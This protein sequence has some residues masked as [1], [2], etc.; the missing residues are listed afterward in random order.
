M[1]DVIEMNKKNIKN[2]SQL[3]YMTEAFDN[4]N[5]PA[6]LDRWGPENVVQVYNPQLG[7]QGVLVIDN[8]AHSS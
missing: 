4:V 2:P 7:V 8:T 6:F 1:L 3:K 5:V